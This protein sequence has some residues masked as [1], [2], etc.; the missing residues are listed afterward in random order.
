MNDARASFSNFGPCVDT[1]APGQTIVSTWNAS[2]TAT[3]TLDGTSLASPHVAGTAALYLA[4]N[5][6]ASPAQ[7]REN[8]I[9]NGSVGRLTGLGSGWNM[10]P[11]TIFTP[12]GPGSN[13]VSRGQQLTSGQSL[14]ANI[15]DHL[16]SMQADGNLVHYQGGFVLFHTRT[17][18]NPGAR[19][20]MQQDGNFVVYTV[21]NVPLFATN[22]GGTPANILVLQDDGNVVVYGP[23]AQVF[24]HTR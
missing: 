4:A 19:A 24:Y 23:G 7:V 10:L 14:R 16:L 21:A 9:Y 8:V 13:S 15:G 20:V 11:H 2:D 5:P 1:Y 17:N 3:N 6:F 12:P 22:T 18:G